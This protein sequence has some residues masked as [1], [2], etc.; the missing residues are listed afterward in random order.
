M[1]PAQFE[2][3]LTSL[4]WLIASPGPV[5]PN[6]IQAGPMTP[7]QFLIT[8][9]THYP[10][11]MWRTSK[12]GEVKYFTNGITETVIVTIPTPAGQDLSL[13]W[14]DELLDLFDGQKEV[15]QLESNLSGQISLTTNLRASLGTAQ[16]TIMDLQS[17]LA[18]AQ[19]ANGSAAQIAQLNE[20]IAGLQL[21]LKA[22]NASVAALEETNSLITGEL[23]QTG[24]PITAI[25]EFIDTTKQPYLPFFQFFSPNGQM[26]GAQWNDPRDMYPSTKEMEATVA[27]SGYEKMNRYDRLMLGWKLALPCNYI[28]D[29]GDN[30]QLPVQTR[31][32]KKGDCEDYARLVMT[33]W[34]LLKVMPDT[35]YN[36]TGSTSFGYHDWPIAYLFLEDI[37]GTP[38][39]HD[40]PGWFIYEATLT[41][42]TPSCPMPL[43]GSGYHVDDGIENWQMKGK[44]KPEFGAQF[45]LAAGEIAPGARRGTK[46]ERLKRHEKLMQH[47]ATYHANKAKR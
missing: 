35:A 31:A 34:R 32:R 47:W 37:K 28:A 16:M 3:Q 11:R 41:Y 43:I 1:N 9:G 23:A 27:A 15:R 46:E 22:A 17:K 42:S 40:G 33:Y 24:D 21:Q 13:S 4:G 8:E 39:E 20:Q 44:V 14:T 18:T 45:E 29:D 10:K 19:Q 5:Q 7:E 6:P 26:E 12:T 25:P 38:V 2:A 36:T 30:H